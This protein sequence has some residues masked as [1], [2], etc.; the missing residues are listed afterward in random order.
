MILEISVTQTIIQVYLKVSLCSSNQRDL[1]ELT[2]L[3]LMVRSRA[4]PGSA[5][6]AALMWLKDERK[7]F[8]WDTMPSLQMLLKPHVK[9]GVT[10]YQ[11]RNKENNI[12]IIWVL[13]L[14]CLPASTIQNSNCGLGSHYWASQMRWTTG[15]DT[16][17]FAVDTSEKLPVVFYVTAFGG[18]LV[19]VDHMCYCTFLFSICRHFFSKAFQR[20]EFWG[21]SCS[22]KVLCVVAKVW[23]ELKVSVQKTQRMTSEMLWKFPFHI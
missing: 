1:V 17:W 23:V 7:Q 22:R 2:A 16:L 21:G 20:E 12:S 5:P 4:A 15:K 18:F 14:R 8:A 10:A 9:L 13:V 11:C 3:L 6:P 19:R